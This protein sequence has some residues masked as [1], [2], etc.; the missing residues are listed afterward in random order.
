MAATGTTVASLTV[1]TSSRTLTNWLGNRLSSL[2]S[3]MARSLTVP[4]VVS[5][6]LS[7]VSS[8]PT[9]SSVFCARSSTRASSAAP[10]F[11]RARTCGS[12]SSGMVKSTEIGCTWMMMQMLVASA[13][14]T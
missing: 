11:R 13:I 1:S 6:T 12:V 4:V 2:L 5:M 7:V 8:L 10:A 3:K 9:P 14:V